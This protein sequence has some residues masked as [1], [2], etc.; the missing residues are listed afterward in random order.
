MFVAP[1]DELDEIGQHLSRNKIFV[2]FMCPVC[3]CWQ[4]RTRVSYLKALMPQRACTRVCCG[5]QGVCCRVSP[6]LMNDENVEVLL[7]VS[8]RFE[9]NLVL[10]EGLQAAVIREALTL[11]A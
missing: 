11:S 1:D 7:L 10:F 4:R 3:V 6:V 9:F 8:R 2:A 5:W